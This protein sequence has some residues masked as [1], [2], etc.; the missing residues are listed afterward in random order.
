MVVPHEGME[1]VVVTIL[2]EATIKATKIQEKNEQLPT[3]L[4]G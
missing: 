1:V 4:P 2:I 3:S